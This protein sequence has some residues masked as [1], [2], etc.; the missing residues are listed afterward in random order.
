M[1]TNKFIPIDINFYPNSCIIALFICN[2]L[3]SI[4]KMLKR[5]TN[6][7]IPSLTRKIYFLLHGNLLK[8]SLRDRINSYYAQI[9]FTP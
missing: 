5:E 8:Q 9:I 7:F 2:L 6:L 4:H 3:R 1:N